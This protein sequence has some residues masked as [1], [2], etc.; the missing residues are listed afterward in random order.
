M[1]LNKDIQH[2]SIEYH[3]AECRYAEFRYAECCYAEYHSAFLIG[4]FINQN[5]FEL[6][7]LVLL[8][9]NLNALNK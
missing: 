7:L 9:L 2:N 8:N 6:G 1:T 4:S 3:S 5:V